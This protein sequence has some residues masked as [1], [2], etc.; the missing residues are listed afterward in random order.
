MSTMSPFSQMPLGASDIMHRHA[1][2]NTILQVGA[3]INS[4]PSSQTSVARADKH[5]DVFV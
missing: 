2:D 1:G 5:G 3:L 4:F